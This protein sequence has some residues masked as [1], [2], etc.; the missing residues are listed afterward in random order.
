MNKG[1]I[2]AFFFAW[3]LD[4]SKKEVDPINLDSKAT[5]SLHPSI[6]AFKHWRIPALLY[7]YVG[8]SLCKQDLF[9]LLFQ[10]SSLKFFDHQT[11]LS[12]TPPPRTEYPLTLSFVFLLSENSTYSLQR[13]LTLPKEHLWN[14][15]RFLL[16][17]R[18]VLILLLP[19][20]TGTDWIPPQ[21]PIT[22]FWP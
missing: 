1:L 7:R 9:F 10:V 11:A 17:L 14:L 20:E 8:D 5:T 6:P 22:R 18:I 2:L 13:I 16:L 12:V 19:L 21:F 4:I 3:L 15:A